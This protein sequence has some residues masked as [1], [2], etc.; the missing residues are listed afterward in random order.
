[1][2]GEAEGEDLPGSKVE[3]ESSQWPFLIFIMGCLLTGII[4]GALG[5][6]I[7]HKKKDEETS[8][9]PVWEPQTAHTK[10]LFQTDSETQT[11]AP[12]PPAP[13][14]YTIPMLIPEPWHEDRVMRRMMKLTVPELSII[15]RVVGYAHTG[16]KKILQERVQHAHRQGVLNIPNQY[17]WA[18]MR[19]IEDHGFAIAESCFIERSLAEAAI[20]RTRKELISLRA[21]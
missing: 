17:Q 10:V 9:A 12:I 4:I 19:R 11:A 6:K 7:R 16:T 18:D 20:I 8:S 21:E 2:T 15:L 1:M 3:E 13:A 14:G 5:E